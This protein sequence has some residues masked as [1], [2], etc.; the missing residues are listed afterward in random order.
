LSLVA[1]IS[2]T[3]MPR[4]ARSLPEHCV[5]IIASADLLIHA[6]D[7]ITAAV[8]D[9]LEAIGPPL[10]AVLGNVD[11]PG[12]APRLPESLNLSVGGVRVSVV[13]D[14]GAAS[15]RLVRMRRRFPDSDVVIFGHSHMPLHETAEGFH[16]FNPGSP[17]ERRRAPRRSMGLLRAL[18]G[19]VALEHI[20]L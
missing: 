16:I 20:W 10:Q 17:T 18:D 13:H 5:E 9:E 3:H 1:L 19:S 14:A 6:G 8:L 4:G 15:G 2:D 11:E 12:L 7:V